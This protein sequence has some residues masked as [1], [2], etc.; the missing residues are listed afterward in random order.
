M[1]IFSFIT[2]LFKPKS[3]YGDVIYKD[4]DHSNDFPSLKV[5]RKEA[6]SGNCEAMYQY[7][8]H[9]QDLDKEKEAWEFYN[10]AAALYHP[11]AYY[12]IGVFYQFGFYVKKDYEKA[13]E[14]YKK[15]TKLK[16]SQAFVNLG[17]LYDNGLYPV[18]DLEMAFYLYKKAS[19]LGN[20]MGSWNLSIMYDKG[21]YVEKNPFECHKYALL[22]L[23]QGYRTAN[24]FETLAYQYNHGEGT[25]VN[26]KESLALYEE[27][28]FKLHSKTAL[29]ALAQFYENG[30]EAVD[31]N[32]ELAADL[33]KKAEQKSPYSL[34]KQG[35]CLVKLAKQ[36]NSKIIMT[37]A[38]DFL[39]KAQY[40]GSEEAT[41]YLDE[42][43]AEINI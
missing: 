32:L 7:G 42:H 29:Y 19:K 18:E 5:L 36:N 40:E 33:Y 8:Q 15:S 9:L 35:C 17:Y 24:V 30:N 39:R 25:K 34:F 13:W 31:I 6:E 16:Y 20:G 11:A 22:A 23:E 38:R 3:F 10:K 41:K 12:K 14:W 4:E 37:E 28:A 43:A 1:S 2:D 27:A 26:H 21:S